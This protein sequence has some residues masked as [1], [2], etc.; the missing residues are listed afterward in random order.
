MGEEAGHTGAVSGS[1]CDMF[2]WPS[3]PTGK[4]PAVRLQIKPV[5][6]VSSLGCFHQKLV[7]GQGGDK[8]AFLFFPHLSSMQR[9]L[10]EKVL[11]GGKEEPEEPAV[12]KVRIPP[13][14]QEFFRVRNSVPLPLLTLSPLL[15]T[16]LAVLSHFFSPF[17]PSSLVTVPS[18][19]ILGVLW[20][21]TKR[22]N[23]PLGIR[24]DELMI[25]SAFHCGY[26]SAWREA[27]DGFVISRE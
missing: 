19:G 9:G 2:S 14:P 26:Q 24:T 18:L 1:V 16:T 5:T 7:S 8:D 10:K 27:V 13:Q 3:I 17:L 6:S 4:T 22:R 15:L 25:H 11:E 21:Q 12:Q 20:A 23:C